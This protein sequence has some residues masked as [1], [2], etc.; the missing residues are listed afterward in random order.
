MRSSLVIEQRREVDREALAEAQPPVDGLQGPPMGADGATDGDPPSPCNGGPMTTGCCSATCATAPVSVITGPTAR[1]GPT[2]MVSRWLTREG[3]SL[4]KS[5]LRSSHTTAT[6]E[7]GSFVVA[8][9]SLPRG[10]SAAW[11][12]S[13]VSRRIC[14]PSPSTSTALTSTG[15]AP[16]S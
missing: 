3:S 5:K 8:P 1:P 6:V 9:V 7:P 2:S 16:C 12:A 13:P 14:R 10:D 11:R 15:K 4:R